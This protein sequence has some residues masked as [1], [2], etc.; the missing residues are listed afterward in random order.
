MSKTREEV[1]DIDEKRVL[2]ELQKGSKDKIAKNCGLSWRK[3][4][5]TTPQCL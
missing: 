4:W 2:Q 5:R 1:K 3:V